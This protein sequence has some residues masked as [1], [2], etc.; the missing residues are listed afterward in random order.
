[1]VIG[2]GGD[3][4]PGTT[5]VDALVALAEDPDTEGC[6]IWANLTLMTGIILIGEVGGTMEFEALRY[7]LDNKLHVNKY[8]LH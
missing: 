4:T 3:R 5:Y 6:R 7:I 1:M 8:T 2:I